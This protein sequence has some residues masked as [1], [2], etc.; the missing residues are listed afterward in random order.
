MGC[1]GVVL[2]GEERHLRRI[3]LHI[4]ARA[5]ILLRLG[6][7]ISLALGMGWDWLERD[8][9]GRATTRYPR[10][11]RIRGKI[12]MPQTAE[13]AMHNRHKRC[14]QAASKL[15]ETEAAPSPLNL[16]Y[17][18]QLHVKRD[19]SVA[20]KHP[21]PQ[22]DTGSPPETPPAPPPRPRPSSPAP[23]HPSGRFR[24]TSATLWPCTCGFAHGLGA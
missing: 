15:L 23:R 14:I 5:F 10:S 21:P 12:N 20:L 13:R 7:P 24:G 16:L 6:S 8:E 22:R 9:T 2:E 18:V 11:K 17:Q 1:D 4:P 3:L 19:A